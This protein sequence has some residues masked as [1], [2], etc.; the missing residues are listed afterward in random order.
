MK[1]ERTS[2]IK[3]EI[4]Y[5]SVKLSCAIILVFGVLQA[6]Q[7]YNAVI[8]HAR[9]VINYRNSAERFLL[10]GYFVKIYDTVDFFSKN[11]MLRRGTCLPASKRAE[12]LQLYK[13][14]QDSDSDI[15]YIYSGYRDG[16]LLINDYR[17]PPDYNAVER[18][19][20]Q[21]AVAAFPEISEGVPYQ[22]LKNEQWLVSVGKAFGA[23]DGGI[24]G[25]VA[26]DC[27]IDNVAALLRC[28]DDKYRTSYSFV[29]HS[30]GK[31]IIHQRQEWLWH[32]ISDIADSPVH[33]E[34]VGG[35]LTFTLAGRERLGYYRRIDKTGWIV[36]T[37]VD[38]DEVTTPVVRA[39]AGS[40]LVIVSVTLVCG[41]ML[42]VS[43]RWRFVG[44]LQALKK[45]LES[46]VLGSG[47]VGR[48]WRY[49]ANEIGAIAA[50][51][52]KLTHNALYDKNLEL[53]KINQQLNHLAVTDPLTQLFN[54]RHMN[55]LL[56]QE[57]RRCSR[58]DGNFAIIMFDID[59]F[60]SINDTFGHQ[61]GDKVLQEIATLIRTSVRV[62][63]AVAR[64]GGEEFL[65]LCPEITLDDARVLAQKLCEL[66][67]RRN[68][69]V[70]R[71]ITIS[72]GVAEVA[73]KR[74]VEELLHDVDGKLYAA[75]QQGRNR[76]VG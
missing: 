49:P 39:I 18:P 31:I 34:D 42:G 7:I 59:W 65:I 69:S 38:K 20:Y 28:P 15:N 56:Q 70:A 24:A 63:D 22:D 27:S 41:Y 36:V 23:D 53:Q 47:D 71:Q 68:F 32:S 50:N 21:A 76:V 35:E 43:L 29:V 6:I 66:V 40:L 4:F 30:N 5:S 52:E 67:A 44:P 19:W 57:W 33:L 48:E 73:G 1:S 3:T 10:E 60:K 13:A 54:R 37:V 61:M 55:E 74:D 12:L 16:S 72:V 11:A 25:V 2:T 8:S 45:R 14:W 64:W 58:Y 17:I 75:K 9:M 51:I 62:T 46:L 26:I